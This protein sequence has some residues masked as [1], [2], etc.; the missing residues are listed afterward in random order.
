M[1]RMTIRNQGDI[2]EPNYIIDIIGK[3]AP[4]SD[5]A[6]AT[7]ESVMFIDHIN[8]DNSLKGRTGCYWNKDRYS[9]SYAH[10]VDTFGHKNVEFVFNRT[11]GV[12]PTLEFS[13]IDDLTN[14]VSGEIEDIENG[15]KRG[16]LYVP[17]YV[18][19]KDIHDELKELLSAEKIQPLDQS[20]VTFPTDS[21]GLHDSY[22]PFKQK[23]NSYYRYKDKLYVL[24]DVNLVE[25]VSFLGEPEPIQFTNYEYYKNGDRIFVEVLPTYVYT[26]GEKNEDGYYEADFDKILF[27]GVPFDHTGNYPEDFEKSDMGQ[28]L[29]VYWQELEKL[30]EVVKKI[31]DK[32]QSNSEE[33]L[34]NNDP[35]M[36]EFE[37]KVQIINGTEQ[38]AKVIVNESTTL[39]DTR[40]DR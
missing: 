20:I 36:A 7:G 29:D 22:K 13:S 17:L 15:I 4:I 30:Q 19:E 34:E 38:L 35:C 32:S 2:Y 3:K 10:M 21:N 25:V 9:N 6:I 37:K 11:V 5:V 12:R 28:Y 33:N 1:I 39:N 14:V 8:G 31:K 24:L 26:N 27:A 40:E 23:N 18:A 16:K